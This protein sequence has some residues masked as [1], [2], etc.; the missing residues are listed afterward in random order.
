MVCGQPPVFS[1]QCSDNT[2]FGHNSSFVPGFINKVLVGLNSEKPLF[3]TFQQHL[4]KLLIIIK[5]Y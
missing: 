1:K 3:L 2:L 5:R 4:L